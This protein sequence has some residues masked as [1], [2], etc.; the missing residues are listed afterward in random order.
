[1]HVREEAR[2]CEKLRV[3]ENRGREKERASVR[4]PERESEQRGNQTGRETERERERERE[5]RNQDCVSHETA[6]VLRIR[7]LCV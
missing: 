2:E 7:D 4:M 3:G 5:I 1:M 6:I